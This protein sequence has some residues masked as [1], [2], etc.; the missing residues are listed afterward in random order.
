MKPLRLLGASFSMSLRQAFAYRLN[1]VFEALLSLATVAGLVAT[2]ALVFTQTTELAGW[3]AAQMLVLLGTYAFMTGLRATFVD[4]NVGD[5]A[6]QVRT[7]RLDPTLLQPAPTVLVATCSRHAPLGLVQSV[8]GLAVLVLGLSRDHVVPGPIDIVGWVV[9][10]AAG[11][12]IGWATSVALACLAFWAPQLSLGILHDA[13]WSFGRYPVD[14]YRGPL[15]LVF[16]YVFPMAA[17]TTWPARTLTDG[18]G[19]VRLGL[20]CGVALAFTGL[21]VGLWRAGLRRY[22]GAT[23]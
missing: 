7:G 14:V 21:A 23:S 11:V 20:G 13:A 10:T 4:T 6:D 22:T 18:I 3:T 8:L 5:F 2:I 19:P 15:R 9:L 17:V 16:T 1:F 12:L